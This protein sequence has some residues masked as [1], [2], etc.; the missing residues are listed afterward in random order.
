MDLSRDVDLHEC[1]GDIV[2]FLLCFL[3]KVRS[4]RRIV[5]LSS[6]V[7]LCSFSPLTRPHSATIVVKTVL[8]VLYSPWYCTYLLYS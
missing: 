2:H 3:C 6:F 1:C 8:R 7:V 4:E 5:N